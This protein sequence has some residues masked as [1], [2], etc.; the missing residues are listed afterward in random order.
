MVHGDYI[1]IALP[2]TERFDCPI[3]QIIQWTQAG[4]SGQEKFDRAT[5]QDAAAGYSPSLLSDD[6]VRALAVQNNDSDDTDLFQA[7]QARLEHE[8]PIHSEPSS[9]D[10]SGESSRSFLG[11]SIDLTE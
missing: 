11:W 4:L 10:S 8:A 1:R 3:V 2:P 9:Y 6:E 7:M 5:G